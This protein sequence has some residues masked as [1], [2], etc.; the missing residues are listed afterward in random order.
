MTKLIE[1]I[2]TPDDATRIQMLSDLE[3]EFKELQ[4]H[5]DSVSGQA[6]ILL[7]AGARGQLA[8]ESVLLLLAPAVTQI[9]RAAVRTRQLSDFVDLGFALQNLTREIGRDVEF[10]GRIRMTKY[11]E[12]EALERVT[13]QESPLQPL[14]FWQLDNDTQ[15]LGVIFGRLFW[16]FRDQVDLHLFNSVFTVLLLAEESLLL[17]RLRLLLLL[18]FTLLSLVL[19]ILSQCLLEG[20]ILL[21]PDILIHLSLF[22]LRPGSHDK[23]LVIPDDGRQSFDEA[24]RLNVPLYPAHHHHFVLS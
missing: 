12:V 24:L 15:S 17:F 21:H 19:L 4:V 3:N 6:S 8:G 10:I 11:V 9:D 7:G 16:D 18:R 20:E 2:E 5:A 13:P 22:S 14:A 1:I 23:G